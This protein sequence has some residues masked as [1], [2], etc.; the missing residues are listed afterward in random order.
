MESRRAK[1]YLARSAAMAR[2]RGHACFAVAFLGAAFAAAPVPARAAFPG[3]NGFLAGTS[4]FCAE[5]DFES[6]ACVSYASSIYVFKP[7]G[8]RVIVPS[9]AYSASRAS[10][11]PDGSR[12]VVGLRFVRDYEDPSTAPPPGLYIL[13]SSRLSAAEA[14]PSPPGRLL[15]ASDDITPPG[16]DWAPDEDRLIVGNRILRQDGSLE[17]EFPPPPQRRLLDTA[18][19]SANN[20]IAFPFGQIE[21]GRNSGGIYTATPDDTR[22]TRL[23]RRQSYGLDWAPS[24]RQL[25]F[26]RQNQLFVIQAD[27]SDPRQIAWN[28]EN[29]VWSP[30][31]RWIAY[32]RQVRGGCAGDDGEDDLNNAV[33]LVRPNGKAT[34]ALRLKYGRG[35]RVC[36]GQLDDWQPRG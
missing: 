27:G 14:A 18:V 7:G 15:A 8:K 22:L 9:L 28:G 21:G 29:P 11:S 26:E 5:A 24:G 35:P 30:D 12:V 36:V 23:T 25:V 10:W 2:A 19:W 6:P 13:R 4:T 16:V 34:H 1:G 33:L 20:V 32:T 3:K 17:R 31:G